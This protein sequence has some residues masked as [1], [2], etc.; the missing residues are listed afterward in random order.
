MTD[1]TNPSTRADGY[2]V[3]EDTYNDEII[4]NELHLYG[5]PYPESAG[6]EI[7]SN[8]T[9]ETAMGIHAIPAGILETNGVVCA[10]W[11]F[12]EVYTGAQNVA[13][14]I[15]FGA[16][17]LLELDPGPGTPGACTVI[18]RARCKI[19]NAGAAD[20]QIAVSE[21]ASHQATAGVLSSFTP[22]PAY[23]TSAVDTTVA[24]SLYVAR[25]MSAAAAGFSVALVGSM[26]YIPLLS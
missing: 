8:T 17:P 1:W 3:T 11:W 6:Y 5:L 19:S 15:Y 12:R 24:Q 23:A 25:K 22:Y 7:I 18:C 21:Y 9:V 10:E 16:T 2:L 26:M 14:R 4:N 13:I 20:A